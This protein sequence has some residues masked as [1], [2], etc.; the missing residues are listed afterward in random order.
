MNA[1]DQDTCAPIAPFHRTP[2]ID[3]RL[4]EGD[5]EDALFSQWP[6]PTYLPSAPAAPRVRRALEPLGDAI[7][8]SWFK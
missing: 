8:D 6:D 7:A 4:L 1:F 5:P 3:A 2:P